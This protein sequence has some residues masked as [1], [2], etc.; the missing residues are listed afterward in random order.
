M[1]ESSCLAAVHQALKADLWIV[2]RAIT[3]HGAKVSRSL[4]S[5]VLN[6][7]CVNLMEFAAALPRDIGSVDHRYQAADS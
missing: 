4:A 6:T 2:C 7:R 1:M 3:N 5:T